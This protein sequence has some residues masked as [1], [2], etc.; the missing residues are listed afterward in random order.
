M[1]REYR[2]SL[3]ILGFVI[4]LAATT[5]AQSPPPASF[6]PPIVGPSALGSTSGG[7]AVADINHDG[8]ADVVGVD[9]GNNFFFSALGNGDG[10]FTSGWVSDTSQ[11]GPYFFDESPQT[12]VLGDF[13]GDGN[14][15]FASGNSDPTSVLVHLGNGD[16]T[17]QPYVEYGGY[18]EYTSGC[19][20]ATALGVGDF[21]GDGKLD[22]VSAT[23]GHTCTLLGNGDGTFRVLPDDIQPSLA[24]TPSF[25]GVGDFNGDGKLDIAVAQ[26]E[27]GN[28][29]IGR[30]SILLG[31][32]DGT[33]QQ[34][35]DYAIGTG[36]FSVAVGDLNGDGK[37]DLVVTNQDPN[38][39]NFGVGN[40]ISIFLGNGDGTFQA[41]VNYPVLGISEQLGP[42]VVIGD[43]NS[44]GKPD[45]AVG[46]NEYPYQPEGGVAILI[47]NGDGTF[48]PA[49]YYGGSGIK[50]D[51]LAIGDF[52]GDGRPDIA[53]QG[54]PPG[55]AV[56]NE[57]WVLLN[58]STNLNTSAGTNVAV[59]PF[60]NTTATSP[61]NVTFP[62]IS[63]AGLTT[64]KSSTSGAP[65]P[66]DFQLGSPTI[67]YELSTTAV[68]S[69]MATVCVSYSPTSFTNPSNV[70]LLHYQSG[71][72]VD[73]TTSLDTVHSIVCGSV[74]SFSPFVA[75]QAMYAA[76]VQQPI[77][78][79]GSSVFSANRGV[80]PVKFALT[81]GNV[82]TCNFPTAKIAV[83]RTSGG[84]PGSV[85][86]SV[87]TLASDNGGYFRISSCQYVYNLSS[88]SLGA[89][90]YRVDIVI[91]NSVVGSGFF[92][93]K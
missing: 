84:S 12:V 38:Y 79:D 16:G 25:L 50:G 29:T 90:S 93:L 23:G 26:K 64:L 4:C 28:P 63:Q 73:V 85:D 69:G 59:Q 57:F 91:G 36:H 37:L 70:R 11:G 52:N 92:G 20:I 10:T 45:L 62:S 88:S 56:S 74:S 8:K 32:G 34:A 3:L 87:Y 13:N 75:A 80:V 35:M 44:D 67:Y 68:F 19:G 51:G 89:G 47:G 2:I 17:F 65:A 60:N 43:F 71:A 24:N 39:P 48:Q 53:V 40:S 82:Q 41:P 49:T 9:Q 14:L 76:Q 42:S 6:G 77:N 83:T 46:T 15:D 61:I 1:R 58:T 30:L 18:P 5:W 66:A 22:L 72:W 33:F 27:R 78:S 55:G 31:N 81:L 54:I 86:E 21:N 7:I